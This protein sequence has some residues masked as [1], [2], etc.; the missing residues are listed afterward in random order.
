MRD[1]YMRCGEGFIICYSITD[2]HSF[3]EVTEYKKLVQKVRPNEEIPVILVGNKYDLENQ[4][5]V[6]TEEGQTLASQFNCQFF[7]T[8]A[9]LRHFV[10]DVFHALVRQIRLKEKAF[11][12]SSKV[13]SDSK[14]WKRM[15]T[16]ITN[17]FK[18]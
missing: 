13:R 5:T 4:R 9:A 6:S 1:Q 16:A 2:R 10:D 3:D 18:M 11:S 8:S 14:K 12:S 7:E 15:K 17:V